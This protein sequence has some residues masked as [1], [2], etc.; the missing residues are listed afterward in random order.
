MRFYVNV[1]GT[2]AEIGDGKSA[3]ELAVY[4]GYTGTEQE[5]LESLHGKDGSTVTLDTSTK[6][7]FLYGVDTGILAEGVTPSI[8]SNTKHWMLGTIDT[9]IVAEG[10]TPYIDSSTKHWF[11]D[12]I[13]TG[14]V[15]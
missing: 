10:K 15:S 4:Y 1:N 3:Y 7:W 9:N 13:D 14:V 5:W 2:L 6:H 11:I 8:D 12:D